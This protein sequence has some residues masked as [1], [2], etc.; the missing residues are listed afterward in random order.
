MKHIDGYLHGSL[1]DTIN[2]KSSDTAQWKYSSASS[3]KNVYDTYYARLRYGIEGDSITFELPSLP[4][5]EKISFFGNRDGF[6]R[7][8]YYVYASIHGIGADT[9]LIATSILF[10]TDAPDTLEH[11]PEI[12]DPLDT[13]IIGRLFVEYQ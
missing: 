7:W 11:L 1:P 3:Q 12:N 8:V 5:H 6:S 4:Q 10:T 9:M 2:F 13:V